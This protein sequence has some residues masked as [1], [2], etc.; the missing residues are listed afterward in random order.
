[1]QIWE[2]TTKK[3]QNGWGSRFSKKISL[4]KNTLHTASLHCS[5][6]QWQKTFAASGSDTNFA[7][8]V[9]HVITL[10]CSSPFQTL[11]GA[12][13]E[14]S[15]HRYTWFSGSCHATPMASTLK[16]SF[17]IQDHPSRQGQTSLVSCGFIRSQAP[18]GFQFVGT[19]PVAALISKNPRLRIRKKTTS[20]VGRFRPLARTWWSSSLR[21]TCG[22]ASLAKKRRKS[23]VDS[24]GRC[25]KFH[26][27]FWLIPT[28]LCIHLHHQVMFRLWLLPFEHQ[29]AALFDNHSNPSWFS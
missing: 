19:L 2:K 17:S 12:T 4:V 6:F 11:P 25:N 15:C 16:E 9:L 23:K 29:V 14:Y 26:S 7:I 10:L 5:L 27:S 22:V 3:T 20:F 1:M 8:F 13:V 28:I 24:F 21:L 18:H